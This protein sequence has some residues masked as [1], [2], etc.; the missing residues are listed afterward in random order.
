M[1]GPRGWGEPDQ[2]GTPAATPPGARPPGRLESSLEQPGQRPF[3]SAGLPVQVPGGP[4]LPRLNPGDLVDESIAAIRWAPR[5]TWAFGGAIVL[6]LTLAQGA[7]A[8]GF[9]LRRYVEALHPGELA[10]LDSQVTLIAASA[11]VSTLAWVTGLLASALCAGVAAVVIGRFRETY[12]GERASGPPPSPGSVWAALR[13]RVAGALGLALLLAVTVGALAILPIG[14]AAIVLAFA[15]DWAQAL[16][17]G[18]LLL[19][20]AAAGA[21]WLLPILAVALPEYVTPT[22]GPG[23]AIA[24]SARLVRG[25][26]WRLVGVWLLTTI[27]LSL[28]NGAVA[29]PFGWVSTMLTGVGDGSWTALMWVLGSAVSAAVTAPIGALVLALAHASLRPDPITA[30]P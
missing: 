21:F 7:L 28:A 20:V 11:V 27:V 4:L 5:V 17:G 23:G 18:T 13:P 30:A 25:N 12:D 15:G 14:V 22:G 1:S 8:A 6:V 29:A 2:Q 10:D 16:V 24:R 26:R 9:G 19:A 3:E